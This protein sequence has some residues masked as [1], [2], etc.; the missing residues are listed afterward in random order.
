MAHAASCIHCRLHVSQIVVTHPRM[1]RSRREHPRDAVRAVP[2]AC[3]VTTRARFRSQEARGH[4]RGPPPPI[5]SSVSP[6][7]TSDGTT[8]SPRSCCRSLR[9]HLLNPRSARLPLPG[10]G[11]L[12]RRH[13]SHVQRLAARTHF[14][15]TIG[16]LASFRCSIDGRAPPWRN[17]E[18]DRR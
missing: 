10:L 16:L 14:L 2:S 18:S 17:R 5:A 6:G 8:S 7:G 1:P 11:H 12:H 3:V 13:R 9:L 4:G 15:H